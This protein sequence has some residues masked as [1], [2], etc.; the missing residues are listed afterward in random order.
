MIGPHDDDGFYETWSAGLRRRALGAAYAVRP[1]RLNLLPRIWW[2][3]AMHM[4]KS[5]EA[6]RRFPPLIVP[7]DDAGLLG[8]C[9]DLSVPT[10]LH[11]YRHGV[12]PFCHLGPMKWWSPS[13]RSVLFF[14]NERVEDSVRKLIR[15]GTYRVSFDYAFA[16]VMEA[17]SK[18]RPGKVALT[19]LTPR[20]MEAYLVMYHAG[21]AHSVEV[22][23][24]KDRLVGGVYGV[25]IGDVFFGES[26]FSTESNTSK[27][28]SAV[29]NGHLRAWGFAFRDTRW[30]T[31][32]HAKMGCVSVPRD[33]FNALV[34]EHIGKSSRTELWEV[35]ERLDLGRR[36]PKLATGRSPSAS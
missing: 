14:A 21:Y 31:D 30:M 29:L 13:E 23:D 32:Y 5:R 24:S 7:R 16:D 27:L 26:Q 8:L 17:C 3:T 6:R 25:A 36:R 11:A 18:P 2:L 15:K 1:K 20:M 34:E 22:W 9:D 10:L 33:K 4:L 19:W 28:A 35:D 12:F